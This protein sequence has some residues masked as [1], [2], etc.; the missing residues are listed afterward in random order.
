MQT[1]VSIIIPSRGRN[2]KLQALV[3]SIAAQA[4]PD[5]ASVE[6]IMVLDGEGG[7]PE[8]PDGLESEVL[9]IEHA[10][11]GA[12]RNAGI[13]RSTGE[14]LLFLNDD[15]VLEPGCVAAHLRAFDNGHRAT[16]GHSPW[17]PLP[18]PCVFDAL[19]SHSPAIFDQ[20]AL[21]PG[22]LHDFRCCWTL[23]FSIRRAELEGHMRPFSPAIRPVYFEDLEFAHRVL[24]P[25]PSVYYEPAAIA[26][27]D[28]RV[29]PRDYF[30][31]ETLLGMM[32][33][34]LYSENPACHDS[35]FPMPPAAHA[36]ITSPMLELDAPDH[37]RM[38][39]AFT[40]RAAEWIPD[41]PR[42][43]AP[44]MDLYNM[45]LPLKRRAFRLGVI[46]AIDRLD[47]DW[48]SRPSRARSL[49]NEDPVFEGL[50]GRG[51]SEEKT[52]DATSTGR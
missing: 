26:V 8:I 46:D 6:T 35:I 15:V 47:E 50:A 32:S 27:H 1:T 17:K 43:R 16:V 10:G 34:V 25:S 36:R 19:V 45:H 18:D 20:S 9:T 4:L 49:L 29:T 12:A 21:V 22:G 23:N 33:V 37:R 39:K 41:V 5:G 24:G 44:A 13:N 52:P 40:T 3:E 14:L 38:L 11:A 28:H 31:R 7:T 30:A 2:T 48:V 51:T 42:S